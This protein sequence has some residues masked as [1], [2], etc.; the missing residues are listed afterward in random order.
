MNCKDRD[1]NKDDDN[2]ATMT[3]MP[4]VALTIPFGAQRNN[5]QTTGASK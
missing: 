4:S 3:T 1:D 5:Q 2:D